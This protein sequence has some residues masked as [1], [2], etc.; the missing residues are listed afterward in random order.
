VSLEVDDAEPARPWTPERRRWGWSDVAAIAVW[1]LAILVFFHDA[2]LLRKAFFYFDISEINL[3]YRDFLAKEIRLGRFSRWMPGLYCGFPLYSESQAGYWHPLKYLLYPWLAT[4][5]AFNLDTVLSVWLTGLATYGWLRR[6]VG[7]PGALTGASLLGLS[8]FVWAHLIHTSMTNA[9]ISVPLTIWGLETGWDRGRL[10]GIAIGALA[11]AFQVFAGHLQDTILTAGVV[12]LYALHRALTE[13]RA[14]DRGRIL[15][16]AVALVVLGL[17]VAAIQWVPSKELLDR[18]PRAGGLTWEQLTYGSWSPELLPTLVVREAYGTRARDT[19]WPDGYYPYHEMNAYLGLIGLALAVIGGAACRDRWVSFWIILA[20]IGGLMMLGRYT[21]VFDMMN[22]V[23]VLGSS[24]I[25]V[26]Y[27]LWVSLAV[28]ALAAVGVDRLSRPGIV[29]LRWTAILAGLLVVVSVVIAVVVYA[30][31][32]EGSGR[33]TPAYHLARFH[34]LGVET[35]I[36]VVRTAVL[37]GLAWFLITRA[38][39]SGDPTIRRRLAAILPVLVIL[40]LL[41]SHNVDAPTIDPAYWTDPPATVDRLK[42]DPTLQ[43]ILG[44]AEKSSGE[45]GFASRPVDFLEVRDE[46]AWSLPPV[47][48]LNSAGGETPLYSRRLLEFNDHARPD[49][50][51]LDIPGVSHLI[52][53]VPYYG[54]DPNPQHVSSAYIHRNKAALPR[55]RLAGRPIYATGEADAVAKLDELGGSIRT[56]LLVEDPDRP[57][58]E[59]AEPSGE[60]RIVNEVPERVE[61]QTT[62]NDPAY[63]VLADTFDPGWTVTVDDNPASIRPAYVAFRAVFLPGGNHRVVFRYEP[64]GFRLGAIATLCGSVVLLIFLVWP[65]PVAELSSAHATLRW[66]RYW[67]LLLATLIAMIIAISAVRFGPQGITIHPRWDTGF[68]R[69][70]WGAKL[71]AI[72]STRN[73]IGR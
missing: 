51:R 37:A 18:S 61:I 15:A 26:R 44:I 54:L 5:Q 50:G 38:A 68:H 40:D 66:P 7:P 39:R 27:H 16:M 53:G 10:R 4:W 1:T 65:K 36:A 42:S 45:P 12:G 22:R 23:P 59:S 34:W 73:A 35:S 69:F 31:I 71:E 11:I 60:A 46:L 41:G 2:A 49:E 57:L 3:P 33:R 72:P 43:R 67:P 56:R 32:F 25:P 48:G 14:A 13:P 62:S 30:P 28:A 24:R 58:S 21:F 63:L 64:A 17:V 70:T 20:M 8:G 52:A 9:L 47:W 55:V 6:H 19:D 29:R